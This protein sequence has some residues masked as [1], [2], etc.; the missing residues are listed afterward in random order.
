LVAAH[1]KRIIHLDIKPEN[2]MLTGSNKVKVCDFGVAHQL[3]AAGEIAPTPRW[4]FAGTPPYMAPEVLESN[5]FDERADIFS[6]G[7]VFYEMLAG[8]HPFRSANAQ[9]T[10]KRIVTESAPSL[11]QVNKKIPARLAR[12][13]EKMLAR[14]PAERIRS[15]GEV[16]R[17]LQI[18]R[19]YRRFF[20]DVCHSAAELFASFKRKPAQAVVSLTIFAV[21]IVGIIHFVGGD[22]LPDKKMLVILPFRVIGQA[23]DERF[24]SQGVS[25]ILT[26]KLAELTI[27]KLL[28]APTSLV[29][30]KQINSLERARAEFGANLVLDGTFQFSRDQV[31]FS[32]A[33]TDVATRRD[34]ARNEKTIPIADPFKLQDGVVQDLLGMLRVKLTTEQQEAVAVYGTSDF[35]AFSLYTSGVGSLANYQEPEN[36]E[37]A[38]NLFSQAVQQDDRYAL[39]H[40]AL[41]RAYWQKFSRVKDVAFLDLSRTS[42]EKA[43]S[44]NMRL[45][46]AQVC[47]GRV[48]HEKGDYELA[49]EYF[50]RAIDYSPTNDDA[51]RAK[52]LAL[53]KL[54]R[55]DEAEKTYQQA[56]D[57]RPQYW[58]GHSWIG[59]FYDRQHRYAEAIDHFNTALALSPGNAQ[60][61]YSMALAYLDDSQFDNAIQLLHKAIDLGPYLEAPYGNLGLTYLRRGQFAEAVAPLEKA[62]SINQNY[63]SLGNVARIYWLVGRKDEARQ[64]YE[65]AI[66][67]GERLLKVNP[68]D[69]G[70]HLLVGRY[71]AMLGKKTEATSHLTES[72][73]KKYDDPHYLLIAA[74]AYVQLNDRAQALSLMERA[75]RPDYG[76]AHIQEEPEL[77]VLKTEPRY[78]ALMSSERLGDVNQPKGES[79]R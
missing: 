5:Q 10:P 6:L 37:K 38:I 27:P 29:R 57:G 18:I 32:Y 23:G 68:S 43:A 72:L 61:C 41:G 67:D 26:A 74:T 59:V 69:D 3:P 70:V 28:V 55:F 2:I 39:A 9:S 21:V 77:S 51:Y 66:Q 13:V 73:A 4:T 65:I 34:L 56:I 24:Y 54:R 58:A 64:K 20:I 42:C 76:P 71:Y 1:E 50:Q 40:A 53:E 35:K 45:S 62:A 16:L 52:G 33:L 78:I 75:I 46:E 19:R 79:K 15:A 49:A 7:L 48:F 47:L 25:E 31:R 22:P 11:R 30:E 36:V 44:L 60:I 14:N 8:V 17:E 63:R 12:L